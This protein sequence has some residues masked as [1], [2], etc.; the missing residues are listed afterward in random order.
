[1]YNAG[2]REDEAYISVDVETAGPHP[3]EYA[4][5]AI[6]ACAVFQPEQAFYAE[7]QPDREASRPEALRVSGLDLETL[8]RSGQAPEA[9]MRA[10][11]NWLAATV[12]GGQ[13]PVFV[14]FNAPFDWSF[15]NAYFHRYLGTNPFG[16]SALDMKAYY[17]GLRGVD[18]NATGMPAVSA[19][20][21][22]GRGLS[23]HAL[24]DARDQARL[25]R[26]ML[27]ESRSRAG[28]A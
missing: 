10:F 27:A 28:P 1:M 15:V 23:H 19:E 24:Q 6:G 5:L 22:G 25:F 26:R 13:P 21:A 12:P 8:R 9:A 18:W 16:H 4:L 11:A 2:M 20:F 17:M 7:L 14:A 3:G